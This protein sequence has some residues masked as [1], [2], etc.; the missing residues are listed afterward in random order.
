MKIIIII[1]I[2]ICLARCGNMATFRNICEKN[3]KKSQLYKTKIKRFV[4][5]TVG[6]VEQHCT[7]NRSRRESSD[8]HLVAQAGVDTSENEPLIVRLMLEL[9]DFS[10]SPTH[11]APTP[12]TVAAGLR[13]RF[14]R[15][16]PQRCGCCC[17]PLKTASRS[18]THLCAAK[19]IS[20]LKT[21]KLSLVAALRLAG[22]TAQHVLRKH[23]AASQEGFTLAGSSMHTMKVQSSSLPRRLHT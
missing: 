8:E 19:S 5:F 9:R 23:F 6:G 15:A 17:H 11:P 7:S 22:E 12:K 13:R 10:F 18:H 3:K 16:S 20:S 1:I 2:I 4:D 21:Q 14:G